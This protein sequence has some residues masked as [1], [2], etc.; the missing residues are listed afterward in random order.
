MDIIDSTGEK[1]HKRNP[2]NNILSKAFNQYGYNQSNDASVACRQDCRP[3]DGEHIYVCLRDPLS[4]TE[5]DCGK[6]F[7]MY[8]CLFRYGTYMIKDKKKTTD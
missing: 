1:I 6:R 2:I 3:T 5:Y 4:G 8:N 7:E